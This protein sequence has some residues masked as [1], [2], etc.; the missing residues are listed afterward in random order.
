MGTVINLV[1]FATWLSSRF[2]V[3]FKTSKIDLIK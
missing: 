3:G 1:I 2:K